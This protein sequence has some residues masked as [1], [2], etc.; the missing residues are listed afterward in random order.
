VDATVVSWR[1]IIPPARG[2][3]PPND[4]PAWVLAPTVLDESIRR[5]S[6]TGCHL[7]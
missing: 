6:G 1:I 4:I 7:E 5:A 2:M 3:P